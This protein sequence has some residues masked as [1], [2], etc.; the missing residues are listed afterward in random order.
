MTYRPSPYG[1]QNIETY[2]QQELDRVA[3]A[4]TNIED[5]QSY[6]RNVAP[7]RPREGF[8]IADGENWDPGQGRGAYRFDET[9]DRFVFLENQGFIS[10]GRW[11]FSTTITAPPN[12]G[13]LRFNNATILSATMMHLHDTDSESVDRST[14]LD[15]IQVGNTLYVQEARNHDNFILF[16]VSSNTDQGAYHDIGMGTK[17]GTGVKPDANRPCIVWRV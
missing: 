12:S 7:E 11:A 5:G 13:Q 16:L 6:M 10:L 2:V 3:D 15:F 9:L 14:L 1:G 8:Y 17:L 4:L